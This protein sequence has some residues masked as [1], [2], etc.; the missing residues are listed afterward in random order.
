MR[1]TGL[2]KLAAVV[3]VFALVEMTSAGLDQRPRRA[4]QDPPKEQK[5]TPSPAQPAQPPESPKK[6]LTPATNPEEAGEAIKISSNLVT[7]PVSV[8]DP[9]G[10]PIKTLAEPEFRLDEEGERQ[11]IQLLGLPGKTPLELALVFDVSG[12]VKERIQF[13][14]QAAARFLRSIL[15]A[16]D[17]VSVFSISQ[18]P[19][20]IVPRTADLEKAI[21]GTASI[22]ATKE[23]TAF[24]DAV[25]RAAQYLGDNAAPGVRRVL[26]VISDGEDNQSDNYHLQ[27]TLRE[28]QR[29]DCVYYSINPSG[30]SIWLN[31]ISQKG[32]EAMVALATETGG[33]AFLPDKLEDLD[34]IFRQ[35]AQELQTQYLLG[36]YS[37]NEQT[38]GKFRRITVRVPGRADLRV[39]S[40]QGYYAPKE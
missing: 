39:R 5:P 19:K 35:I 10:Q 12:S 6:K 23:A 21:T 14:Q 24:F 13:E 25:A 26:V 20:L 17:L 16:T 2:I 32:Q 7:V 4:N 9:S 33:V 1:L 15:T 34:R 3:A 37:T 28:L 18:T 40:R 11:S 30:P 22:P 38:D 8:T 27:A 29:N 36:Y 31:K